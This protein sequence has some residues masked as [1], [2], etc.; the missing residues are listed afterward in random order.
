M[1]H[2][3]PSFDKSRHICI[4]YERVG[5]YRLAT[6]TQVQ[7]VTEQGLAT[8]EFPSVILSHIPTITIKVCLS[9]WPRCPPL[10]ALCP[11]PAL[12][13]CLC[14]PANSARCAAPAVTRYEE[15]QSEFM[16]FCSCSCSLVTKVADYINI[17]YVSHIILCHFKFL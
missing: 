17:C 13:T 6:E 1:S 9:R 5:C 12:P 11:M 7:W 2:F 14:L 16:Q 4:F 10:P 8:I 15:T 3:S